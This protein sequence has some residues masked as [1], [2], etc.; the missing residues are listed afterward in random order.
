MS[1]LGSVH[2]FVQ[3]H[4]ESPESLWDSVRSEIDSFARL[5]PLLFVDVRAVWSRELLRTD[6]FEYGLYCFVSKWWQE[7][8]SRCKM[9]GSNGA[10]KSRAYEHGHAIAELTAAPG[11]KCIMLFFFSTRSHPSFTS[12]SLLFFSFPRSVFSYFYFATGV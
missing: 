4:Y 6:V 3:K 11:I 10:K 7:R 9:G 8:I 12:L 5:I 1:M 2:A